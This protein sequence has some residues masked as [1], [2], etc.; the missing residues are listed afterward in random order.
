MRHAGPV[1]GRVRQAVA[2]DDGDGVEMI[3]EHARREHASDAPAH[4]HR[5]AAGSGAA[6]VP[7]LR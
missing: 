2:F 1:F 3:G 7:K 5:V 6:F 4:H